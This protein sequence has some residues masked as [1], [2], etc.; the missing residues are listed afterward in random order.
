MIDDLI[1]QNQI[2]EDY[3]LNKYFCKYIEACFLSSKVQINMY[4][5]YVYHYMCDFFTFV[6]VSK[7]V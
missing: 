5:L 1:W 3:Y 6:Y 7:I 4:A 2:I